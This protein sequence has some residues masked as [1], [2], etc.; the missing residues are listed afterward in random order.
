MAWFPFAWYFYHV[1]ENLIKALVF[2]I[3][4]PIALALQ[5]CDISHQEGAREKSPIDK[6]LDDYLNLE[7]EQGLS[8]V[9]AV[10]RADQE[11]LYKCIGYSDKGRKIKNSQNTVFD[12][13]S[14]TKQFTGA[15][16]LKLE[17]EGK[18]SVEDSL[19]R[20][21][22]GI[23]ED[24]IGIT[25][26]HLLTHSSGFPKRIG[27]DYE[28][29]TKEDFLSRSFNTRLLFEPGEKFDYSHLGYSLLGILIENVSGMSYE[30]FLMLHFFEPIG[31]S[32]TGYVLPEWDLSE[33]ANGYRKCKNWG[34]PMDLSWGTEGPYWNLKA[35]A[36]LLSTASDLM[37]WRTALEGDNILN[38]DAKKKYLSK[39]IREGKA[40]SYYSYGW[41]VA[42]SQRGTITFAHEGGNGK[43]YSDWINYPQ[44]QVSILVMTNEYSPGIKYPRNGNLNIASEIARILFYPHHEPNI[45]IKTLQCLD[46]LPNNRIGE[47]ASSFIEMITSDNEELIKTF[48]SQYFSAYMNNKYTDDKIFR[49]LNAIQKDAGGA[50]SITQIIVIGSDYMELKLNRLSDQ[51][52]I[53]IQI[54]FDIDDDYKIRRFRYNSNEP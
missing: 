27:S 29:L 7:A 2:G 16:I 32:R 5:F 40:S 4:I 46:S 38:E 28:S 54:K 20:Y 14:L 18:L 50:S 12:I 19:I 6:K 11:I 23:P 53:D 15:A 17:M 43:F 36:G 21:F 37:A 10:K 3:I 9:I 39:H 45:Q 49:V 42:N 34:K 52:K 51:I 22:P 44:E 35:N 33:V 8:G 48:P 25:I 31:M 30:Q 13:G 41:M 47:V 26:H 24:K 1:K